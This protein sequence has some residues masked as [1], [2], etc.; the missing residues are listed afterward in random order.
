MTALLPPDAP[1]SVVAPMYMHGGSFASSA[2][3]FSAVP[4]PIQAELFRQ[5][6][7]SFNG[8]VPEGWCAP[9]P[10]TH[11]RKVTAIGETIEI[12]RNFQCSS[13]G[14]CSSSFQWD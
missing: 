7:V 13:E 14:R 1:W 9:R 12:A 5:C 8:T 10:G 2:V 6:H 4:A 3:N 11:E